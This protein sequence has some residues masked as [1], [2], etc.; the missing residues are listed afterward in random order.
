[1]REFSL[2]VLTPDHPYYEGPCVSLV[3][4]TTEGQYGIMAGHNNSIIALVPGT[5]KITLPNGEVKLA[6]SAM[7]LLKVE[8]NNVLVLVNSAEAPEEID[9]KRAKEAAQRAEDALIEAKSQKEYIL[10]KAQMARAMNRLKV[11]HNSGGMNKHH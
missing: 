10:A 7:G 5:L 4:T 11:K 1:M 3:A 6:A 9:E 2:R 8:N